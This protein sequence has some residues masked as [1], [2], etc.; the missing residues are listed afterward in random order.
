MIARQPACMKSNLI[1]KREAA[2]YL[3]VSVSFVNS[4]LAKRKLPRVRLGYRVTKIPLCAVEKFVES[5]TEAS[6]IN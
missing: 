4:L 5:R 6:R 1:T 2:E 3:G